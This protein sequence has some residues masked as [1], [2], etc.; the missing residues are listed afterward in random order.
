MLDTPVKTRGKK[1]NSPSDL[2]FDF[3]SGVESEL[4]EESDVDANDLGSKG[5]ARS[6]VATPKKRATPA[7]KVTPSK[8]NIQTPKSLKQ[9]AAP[10]RSAKAATKPI[11]K[12]SKQ[13][14]MANPSNTS[15]GL[16]AQVA[17]K[18]R[19]S[20]TNS[21]PK[22]SKAPNPS[23]TSNAD[24]GLVASTPKATK[25][26]ARVANTPKAAA[27]E[28]TQENGAVTKETSNP[29][30]GETKS[31]AAEKT[32]N[33]QLNNAAPFED[34]SRLLDTQLSSEEKMSKSITDQTQTSSFL[35]DLIQNGHTSYSESNRPALKQ[36]LVNT[37]LSGLP[38]SKDSLLKS[39]MAK[40]PANQNKM[41]IEPSL[42]PPTSTAISLPNQ[43]NL[44]LHSESSSHNDRMDLV[45]V[46]KST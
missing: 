14:P 1:G 46:L 34:S 33:S 24:N 35:Q 20:R 7:G 31:L 2:D 26:P 19:T 22:K 32:A 27:A 18:A 5:K 45:P 6:S 21:A 42:T 38:S 10:K 4:E 16:A 8:N 43:L 44:V 15:K 29:A 28:P 25:Q 3:A 36:K 30:L 40:I 41:D 9:Q 39:T 17:I 13:K 11:G 37:N 12:G 23:S